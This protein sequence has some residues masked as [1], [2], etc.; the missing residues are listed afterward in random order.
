[1]REGLGFGALAWGVAL[2][3][4]V[5]CGTST[6][7]PQTPAGASDGGVEGLGT[8]QGAH[9]SG[10]GDPVRDA[11]GADVDATPAG[12]SI[13]P[14]TPPSMARALRGELAP[15]DL[16]EIEHMCALLTSCP[17]LP[18]PP[19]L[20]PSDFVACVKKMSE[21]MTAASGIGFSLTLRECGIEKNSC[22]DLRACAL[23]GTKADSCNGRG[24]D[25][26]V[27]YCDADGRALSCY[28]DQIIAV[29]DCPRGQEQCVVRGGLAECVLGGCPDDVREGAPKQC[30]PS[31]T[32]VVSCEKGKLVSLDCAAFGL[33]C[34]QVEGAGVGCAT[35]G[36]P[37]AAG[38]RRC[39]GQIAVG[40]HNGHEVRVDCPAAGLACSGSGGTPVGACL[41]LP[42]P[43]DACDP[44]APARCDG[45][46]IKYCFAGKSRAFNCGIVNFTKC[47]DDNKKKAARCAN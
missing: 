7:D 20:I 31:G 39:E 9:D 38:A 10:V 14:G 30:S 22:N 40:C 19:Q 11:A 13:P 29:R 5:S 46:K 23:R 3:F 26:V 34:A 37:C 17:N 47:D 12:P 8:P 45:N 44:S 4:A 35:S 25:R 33:K 18:L 2:A 32:R 1:M 42:P 43:K 6:K 21:D 16:D 28:R 41:A 27:G 36:P 24:H 15:P